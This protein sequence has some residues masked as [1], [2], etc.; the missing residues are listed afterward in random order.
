[1]IWLT[2]DHMRYDHIAANGNPAMVTPALDALTNA[3]VNFTDC[4]AQNPLCMPSRCSFMTGTYPQ[5]TGVTNNG[6]CL[7]PDYQPTAA[8]VMKAAGYQT[9]QIGKLHLQPHENL[10]FDPRPRQAYGFDV[11]WPSE[12]RGNYSDAYYHW[13]E[14]KYP[15]HAAAFRVPRSTDTDRMA[16]EF[17]PQPIDAPW[18]ASHAGWVV[19]AACRYLSVRADSCQFMHLGFYNPHPPLRPVREAWELCKDRKLPPRICKAQEWS[20]KPEPLATMLRHKQNWTDE[21]FEQYRIGLAAM[22]TEMDFAIAELV[23]WLRQANML[24]DTLLIFGSDHG[25]FAGDHGLTHKSYAYYDQVMRVPLVM[26]WPAGFGTQRRDCAGLTELIDV[27]PTIVGLCGGHVP[28]VMPGRDMSAALLAGE[29]PA[30]REDVLAYYD[31]GAAMLRTKQAKY[32]RY[33]PQGTEVLYDLSVDGGAELVNCASDP[34]YGELLSQMRLQLLRRSLQ[35]SRSRL[36][37]YHPF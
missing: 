30:G 8:T 17:K 37:R 4:F 23:R 11:F 20:D 2:S 27:L 7:P 32:L 35:A 19:D 26:H 12:E 21:D 29:Q 3:A 5:Q 33:E 36:P 15:Q 18:Q 34:Q 24:D 6:Q 28:Q 1:M 10:D 13:L 25:D 14:G 31:S 9:A 16:S 22:V